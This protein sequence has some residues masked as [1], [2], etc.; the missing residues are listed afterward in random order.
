MSTVDRKEHIQIDHLRGKGTV[1]REKVEDVGRERQAIVARAVQILWLAV[2]A[3]EILLGARL[4]LKL[5]A[6]NPNVPFARFIYEASAWFLGPFRGLT[7]TP[8]ANGIVFEIP[9]IIAMATY[10]LAGWLIVKL[11]WLVF[12]PASQ[13]SVRTYEE[14]K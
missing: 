12:K 6:A 4:V 13:R 9:T 1:R 10:V 2:T 3:L 8:S 5:M 11:I 14:F 7:I